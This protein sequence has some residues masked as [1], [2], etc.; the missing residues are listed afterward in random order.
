MSLDSKKISK[1][2]M[3]LA[4][5]LIIAYFAANLIDNTYKLPPEPN[6]RVNDSTLLGIDTNNNNV[7]DD[8]ERWI[9]QTYDTYIP[10]T[11]QDISVESSSGEFYTATIKECNGEPVPYHQIVRE[12]A[13]QYA[14]TYQAILK[15]PKNYEKNIELEDAAYYCSRYFTSNAKEMKKSILIDPAVASKLKAIQFNTQIRINTYEQY[16]EQLRGTIYELV[17]EF[18]KKYC[19]FNVDA[20]LEQ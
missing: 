12:I 11:E 1:V 9:Y 8:V 2:A 16:A 13:M 6:V 5:M 10:C 17:Q 19:D 20:L 3:L 14:R 4:F 15:N 7:R 18:Y